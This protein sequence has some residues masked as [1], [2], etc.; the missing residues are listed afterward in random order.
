[1]SRIE[2]MISRLDVSLPRILG[3]PTALEHLL[4]NGSEPFVTTKENC[5]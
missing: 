4:V 1:M 5:R 2:L 3:D